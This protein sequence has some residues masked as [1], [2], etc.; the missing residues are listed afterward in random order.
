M[1]D[2]AA[3]TVPIVLSVL[4]SLAV[5]VWTAASLHAVFRKAGEQGWKAWVPILNA[6]TLLQLG[7]LS[8]WWVLL[9]LFP[10]AVI[11][12]WVLL[13]VAYRRINADF[14]LGVGMTVLA[15]LLF[16]VWS[17]IVGWGGAQWV[18]DDTPASRPGPLRTP[19][20]ELDARFSAPFAGG[21]VE[22]LVSSVPL[23]RP[24]P[25]AA[26]VA[27][28]PVAVGATV[29][30][31]EVAP[32]SATLPVVPGGS[33]VRAAPLGATPVSVDAAHDGPG[34]RPVPPE[35]AG[36]PPPAT[37]AAAS[38][39]SPMRG[40]PGPVTSAP[41]QPPAPDPDRPGPMRA[42]GG[43]LAA[44]YDDD[45]DSDVV[46]DPLDPVTMRRQGARPPFLPE[47]AP[48]PRRALPPGDDH[49]S[50]DDER[51]AA[52]AGSLPGSA[53]IAP[54]R[55]PWAP[56]A[57]PYGATRAPRLSPEPTG[58]GFSETSAEVSAVLGAPRLG[59]PM[60]ARASVSARRAPAELPDEDAVLDQT[61][62]ASRR[63]STWTLIPPLGA[64]IA[65]TRDVLVLGRR[66]SADP[67]HPGAQLVAIADETRT[68]SKTHARLELHDGEWTIVDLDSTNG[69][70]LLSPD[71]RETELLPGRPHVATMRFLLGDAEL[72]LTRDA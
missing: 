64:P 57:A 53:A 51:S 48:G 35:P 9:I 2:P 10:P 63:R 29:A 45:D 30:A 60:A 13:I 69:V 14:G 41:D 23:S 66:P 71:G 55:D 59:E 43:P 37:A 47:D 5:Y 25:A 67:S 65:V 22:P 17:S 16:P 54:A 46:D 62:V 72:R 56:P 42:R 4:L 31:R 61:M 50:S 49:G 32:A 12:L 28:Q 19:S 8:G 26:E 6:V 21:D 44:G 70:V 68:M 36:P 39:R 34:D 20:A 1:S 11:V 33:A 18:G 3:A 40:F 24:Q 7:R 27:P 58:D 15:A 38:T 52:S